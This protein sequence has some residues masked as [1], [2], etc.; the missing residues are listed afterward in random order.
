MGMINSNWLLPS[1]KDSD[2]YLSWK[3]IEMIQDNFGDEEFWKLFG[4]RHISSHSQY[5]NEFQKPLYN[6]QRDVETVDDEWFGK[7]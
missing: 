3:D 6:D 4:Y 5:L 2:Q 1:S 7:S